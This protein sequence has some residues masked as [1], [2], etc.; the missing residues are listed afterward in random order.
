MQLRIQV[1]QASAGMEDSLRKDGWNLL[2]EGAD[3]L[4]ASHAQVHE[5][6][7][8]RE[9]LFHLGLLTS[10]RIRIEFTPAPAPTRQVSA[11]N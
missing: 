5:A 3:C 1:L 8:A 9:R 6:D 2:A 10:R 7:E 11:L 4:V